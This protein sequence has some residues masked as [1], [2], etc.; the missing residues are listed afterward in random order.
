MPL[1]KRQKS[2]AFIAFW[3][4]L[5]A[6]QRQI[7]RL[8]ELEV[9]VLGGP[10]ELLVFGRELEQEV[11]ARAIVRRVDMPG[12]ATEG[13]KELAVLVAHNHQ[14]RSGLFRHFV[15]QR[16]QGDAVHKGRVH[17]VPV[18]HLEAAW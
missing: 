8:A 1:R 9:R 16:R 15:V 6:T 2:L 13:A 12:L 4:H 17:E 3:L 7:V 10:L 18:L 5:P 11:L 14:G